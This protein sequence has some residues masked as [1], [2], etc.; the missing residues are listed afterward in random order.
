MADI[1]FAAS[2]KGVVESTTIISPSNSDTDIEKGQH[3]PHHDSALETPLP[4]RIPSTLRRINGKIESFAGL[5]ARGITRVEPDERHE[6]SITKYVQMSLLWFSANLTANNLAVGFLGPLL[7]QLGFTD[8][9]LMGV[10]GAFV[11][12]LITAYMSTWGAA[13]GNRTLVCEPSRFRECI[14]EIR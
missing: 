1:A 12:S 14:F 7:F 10:W 2:E 6:S 3:H 4:I 13:S 8:A 9:A 11:G 5:E